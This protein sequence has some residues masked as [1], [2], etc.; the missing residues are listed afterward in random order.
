M[1]AQSSPLEHFHADWNHSPHPAP[2]KARPE[3]R[4]N[5][6]QPSPPASRGGRGKGE[7]GV[8]GQ[9]EPALESLGKPLRHLQRGTR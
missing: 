6:T 5:P 2:G 8:S 3:R 1:A 9:V 7:G 4:A